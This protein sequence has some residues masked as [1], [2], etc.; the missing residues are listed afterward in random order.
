MVLNCEISRA[1]SAKKFQKWW[2]SVKPMHLGLAPVNPE[3]A[4]VVRFDALSNSHVKELDDSGRAVGAKLR[5]AKVTVAVRTCVDMTDE[6]ANAEAVLSSRTTTAASIG[7]TVT[8]VVSQQILVTLDG[9]QKHLRRIGKLKLRARDLRT[10]WDPACHSEMLV[11]SEGVNES[12]S[13]GE[14]WTGEQAPITVIDFQSV[15]LLTIA[16]D[17]MRTW[18]GVRR[19]LTVADV[20]LRRM[21][22]RCGKASMLWKPWKWCRRVGSSK[23]WGNA[24]K[25]KEVNPLS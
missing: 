7:E 14:E 17:D 12:L 3:H 2:Q 13:F 15:H 22:S 6:A 18:H 16:K 23:A 19:S 21:V 10:V 20:H 11:N 9:P 25:R 8:V 4:K 5:Q 1:Q 24:A